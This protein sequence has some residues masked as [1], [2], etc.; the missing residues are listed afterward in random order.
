MRGSH[1][2]CW[3]FVN[4]HDPNK[5]T[6]RG[7]RLDIPTPLILRTQY[8]HFTCAH[9]KASHNDFSDIIKYSL[10]YHLNCDEA[11][12]VRARFVYMAVQHVWRQSVS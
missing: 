9:S 7:I 2:D 1:A 6:D 10:H 3:L 12:P 8:W 5:C 11:C 4:S